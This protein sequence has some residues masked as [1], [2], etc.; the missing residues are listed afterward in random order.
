MFKKGSLVGVEPVQDVFLMEEHDKACN[1]WKKTENRTLLHL[2]AH[3]DFGWR[4]SR[5]LLQILVAKTIRDVHTLLKKDTIWDFSQKIDGNLSIY[6]ALRDGLIKEYYWVVPDKHWGG[7]K[8]CRM[9]E[10]SLRHIP[11]KKSIRIKDNRIIIK[12]D[13]L[14]IITC[15]LVDLPCFDESVILDVDLDF[16]L[17]RSVFKAAPS[18]Y[19]KPWIW[20][21]QISKILKNKKIKT[22]LVTIAYS[23][24][25]GYTPAQYKYLGDELASMIKNPQRRPG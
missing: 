21:A 20:P 16:L 5:N 12:F 1:I 24:N 22:D 14:E 10:Q 17:I 2:D 15:R 7:P 8:Q 19:R 3:M 13:N 4:P 11:L 23:V 9:I 18:S 25:D 6:S